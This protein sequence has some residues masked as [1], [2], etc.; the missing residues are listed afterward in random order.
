MK[1]A[2]IEIPIAGIKMEVEIREIG[3]DLLILD[4]E[5][6]RIGYWLDNVRMVSDEV[7]QDQLELALKSGNYDDYSNLKR[8]IETNEGILQEIWVFP[9]DDDR[10]RIVDGNTRVL[11]YRDLREKYPHKKTYRSIRC[12]VLPEDITETAIN[13]IRLI[14]HLRGV[15]DWQAYER[16]RMLYILWDLRGYSEEELQNVTKLK[17]SDIRKWREAYKTMNEQFLPAYGDQPGALLKFSYFVEL[18]NKRIKEGMTR[19]GLTVRDFCE[20]VG[21]GEI[22]R[23]QDV[24]D[25]RDI[26]ENK[27]IAAVLKEEGFQ[28]A[29]HELSFVDPS[30]GSTLFEHIDKCISGLKQMSREEEYQIISGNEPAKRDMIYELHKE[31]S[32]F[33]DTIERLGE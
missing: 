4:E 32:K 33:V 26:L 20:W 10:Y 8:A 21:T 13:F 15:N 18:E 25:L 9:I 17:I 1:T 2:T 24:R 14:A 22:T 7:T 23:A 31:V 12:R 28:A 5:N 30:H 6:P 29:K 3:T 16:A 27:Q 11:I 19:H